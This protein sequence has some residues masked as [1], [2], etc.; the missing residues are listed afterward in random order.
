MWI[1]ALLKEGLLAE[2]AITIAYSYI[3]P[4]ITKG[5]YHNGTIGMAKKHLENTATKLTEKLKKIK[6]RSFVSVNKALVTQSSSAIPFIPLYFVILMKVMKEKGI[7]EEC[8]QQICRLFSKRLCSSKE[9]PVD[10]K[11]RIRID[12][13]EMR[14]DV[15]KEVLAVWEIINDDNITKLADIE[16]FH[17]DFLRLFGFGLEGVNYDADVDI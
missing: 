4:D 8:I 7:H 6:G 11:G 2:R 10:E 1:D 12:D 16:G 9:V 5:V 15:Q 3:G 13:W 14:E 17:K